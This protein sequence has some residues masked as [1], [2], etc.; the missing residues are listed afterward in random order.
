MAQASSAEQFYQE[1]RRLGGNVAKRKILNDLKIVACATIK[2]CDVIS[3]DDRRTMQNPKALKAYAVV[4]VREGYHR[5][6][7]FMSYAVLKRA[8]TERFR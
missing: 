5:P 7:G 6:P 3:S 4:S 2:N 8:L 1:Y